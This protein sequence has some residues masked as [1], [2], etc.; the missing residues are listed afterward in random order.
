MVSLVCGLSLVLPFL[1][2]CWLVCWFFGKLGFS[3][4]VCLSVNLFCWSI[5]L[6]V[7][8]L[9]HLLVCL[10]VCLTFPWFFSWLFFFYFIV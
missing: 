6:F 1:L 5:G 4:L 2:F 8:L 3:V 7:G 9:V 10:L